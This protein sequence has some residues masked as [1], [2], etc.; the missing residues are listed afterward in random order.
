MLLAA[1]CKDPVR[2]DIDYDHE[3]IMSPIWM[4]TMAGME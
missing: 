1:S 4:E 3:P 2:K